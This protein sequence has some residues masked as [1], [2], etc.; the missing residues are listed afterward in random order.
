MIE[1]YLSKNNN[2]ESQAYG[3]GSCTY[4]GKGLR[5]HL[6]VAGDID[7]RRAQH[8]LR[9]ILHQF[10]ITVLSTLEAQHV[11]MML[12]KDQRLLQNLTVENL[13]VHALHGHGLK[14]GLGQSDEDG[15][16]PCP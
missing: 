1:L 4:A 11:G 6:Q 10:R 12:G 2:E 5:R 7:Q 9:L 16:L 8:R 13:D 3:M 15:G 14:L